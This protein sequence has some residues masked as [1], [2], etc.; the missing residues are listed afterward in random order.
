MDVQL[1]SSLVACTVIISILIA[2]LLR[3]SRSRLHYQ[4]FIYGI[5][6]T[7]WLFFRMLYQSTGD[8][9]FYK[10]LIVVMVLTPLASFF[11]YRRLLR[12]SD[13]IFQYLIYSTGLISLIFILV[14]FIQEKPISWLNFV[15]IIYV[16]VALFYNLFPMYLKLREP[17][18]TEER[19]RIFYLSTGTSVTILLFAFGHIPGCNKMVVTFANVLIAIY[20]YQL[21]ATISSSRLLDL[22]DIFGKVLETALLTLVIASVYIILGLWIATEVPVFVFN[23]I[24]ASLVV[25]IVYDPLRYYLRDIGVKLLFKQKVNMSLLTKMIIKQIRQK[26]IVDDVC[27]V[28]IDNLLES[29]RV[30][31]CSIYLEHEV[32]PAFQLMK[33]CGAKPYESLSSA[34]CQQLLAELEKKRKTVIYEEAERRVLDLSMWDRHDTKNELGTLEN[35]LKAM[36]EVKSGITVPIIDHRSDKVMGVINLKDERLK[37]AYSADEIRM[38]ERLAGETG[39]AVLNSRVYEKRRE[40]DRLAVLGEMSAG[41]AHEIRNP[42]GAIKGAAQYLNPDSL[43]KEQGEFLNIVISEVNRLNRVVTQFLDYAKPSLQDMIK[44]DINTLIIKTVQMVNSAE[45]FSNIEIFTELDKDVPNVIGESDRLLQ[46]LLNLIKNAADA[47]QN[48]DNGTVTVLSLIEEDID[49]KEWIK[50]QVKDNGTGIEPDNIKNL[51]IPFFTTKEKG[52]GLGLPICLRIIEEHNGT[53]D[54]V[55]KPGLTVFTLLLPCSY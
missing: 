12:F 3:K 27:T 17:T 32:R 45:Q 35:L 51:F 34:D 9:F 50:I 43:A 31:H 11:L 20:F 21:Y 36:E 49:G 52:V 7:L 5:L 55:S 6:F 46:V 24:I 44:V 2:I 10:S 23:T 22:H 37:E 33:Y 53:I 26:L 29:D 8:N 16:F 14:I 41:L 47:V 48:K 30:T 1:H 19:K 28:I 42:L 38:L 25:L 15:I 54:V 18:S 40:R 4:L 13:T 39:I